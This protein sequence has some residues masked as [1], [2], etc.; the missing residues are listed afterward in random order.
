MTEK[1]VPTAELEVLACIRLGYSPEDGAAAAK[2][3]ATS[4]S[5]KANPATLTEGDL[6]ALLAAAG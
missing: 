1:N 6:L 3:A 4:S 5:M 2:A